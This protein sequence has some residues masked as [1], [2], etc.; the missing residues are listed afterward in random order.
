M[1]IEKE[2]AQ[3]Q[4]ILDLEEGVAMVVTDLHGDWDAYQRY[5]NCYL[6]R[7]AIGEVDHLI[8]LGDF[9]HH[10]GPASDDKSVEIV[11]D[12]IT[13]QKEHPDHVHC[14][15]GNHEVPHI[16]SILL[17][18]GNELFTPR[19]EKAM[20]ED[21]QK[22]I[23]FFDSLPFY[24]R[25]K[26]G[27]TLCHAGASSAIGEKGSLNWLRHFSH[28]QLLADAKAKITQEKRPSL[29]REMRGIYGRSYNELS[30]TLFAVSGI[31]DPRYDDF[32]IG[33]IAST[34]NHQFDLLWSILFTRNE[35]EFGQHGYN[36]V[37]NAMLQTLSTD[38]H[39][40]VALVS[41]HIDCQG[42]YHVINKK[43]LRLA[44]AKHAHPRESGLYLMLDMSNGIDSVEESLIPN[45]HS[46][47]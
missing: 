40:Q 26:A 43:Q 29:M 16:Y 25:T 1:T 13:L 28:Q 30:R 35:H 37:L 21:R 31:N 5:R 3:P 39:P 11:L 9:I 23:D 20:G 38:Y 45:L 2:N 12:L 44:S 27:V 18:K 47:F 33:T 36:I 10:S 4:R 34:D 24:I 41:G 6:A 14:L 8:M 42:G 19:F 22:I 32:L 7:K 17:Q 15:L 46:V